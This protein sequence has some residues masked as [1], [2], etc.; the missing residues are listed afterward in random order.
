MWQNIGYVLISLGVLGL[1]GW[2]LW[3]F[4]T[5]SE[6]PIA[7]RIALGIIGVGV[8]MLLGIAVKDRIH[9]KEKSGEADYDNHDN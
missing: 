8:L 9:R 4:F 1:A 6:I 5:S 2:G 3:N 7:I